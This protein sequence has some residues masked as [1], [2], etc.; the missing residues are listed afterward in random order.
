MAGRAR[1]AMGS[2]AIGQFESNVCY[3]F[4]SNHIS[5]VT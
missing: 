5:R 4:Q 1:A 3:E 2:F